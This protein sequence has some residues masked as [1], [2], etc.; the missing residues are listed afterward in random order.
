M[1]RRKE[2]LAQRHQRHA[3]RPVLVVLP[4][5]VEHD[6]ALRLEPLARQ[7]RQQ[8][9]HAIRFHPERKLQ[10]ARRHDLPVIGP[11]GVR[12]S[13]EQ[14]TRL[15]QRL[16]EAAVVVLGTLEHQVLE[17]VR[18]TRAPGAFVLRADVVPEVDRDDGHPPIFV[19]DDVQAVGEGAF[20]VWQLDDGRHR[21]QRTGIRGILPLLASAALCARIDTCAAVRSAAWMNARPAVEPGSLTTI[22]TPV[23]LPSRIG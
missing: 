6:V 20:G 12:G 9:P 16:K 2:C 7:R 8:V 22:G 19:D 3:V 5:L 10:G 18:E 21:V 13:V 4:P 23:S 15:L 17:Q 14:R 1:V 11:V